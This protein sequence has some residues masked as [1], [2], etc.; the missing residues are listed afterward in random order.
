MSSIYTGLR[1][2]PV[3]NFLTGKASFKSL[4]IKT[5]IIFKTFFVM[6]LEEYRMREIE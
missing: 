1:K 4:F 6:H 2:G 5:F 3:P